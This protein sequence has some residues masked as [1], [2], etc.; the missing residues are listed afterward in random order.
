MKKLFIYTLVISY[1]F[2]NENFNLLNLMI[3]DYSW[4]FIKENNGFMIF[5]KNID[6][7]QMLLIKKETN[8]D[9]E[10]IFSIIKNVE[11]YSNVLTSQNVI[12]EFLG[13]KQDTI[14][15][16]QK[17][18]NFMPFTRD[19]QIIFKMFDINE[20]RIAWIVMNRENQ[21]YDDYKSEDTKILNIG[22]GT[23]EYIEENNKRYI[24]HR[25]Y[26]DTE[27]NIPDFIL[28]PARR[29]SVINVME[30]VLNYEKELLN[31]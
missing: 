9:K 23:W 22:L 24:V 4:D 2:S 13:T 29:N 3:D 18:V 12:S 14:F 31:E 16:Y 15:G 7:Y 17:Y 8:L 26:M 11:N 20:D 27:L 21:L 1:L 30:D 5:E 28:N 19:R 10:T 25:F 6:D